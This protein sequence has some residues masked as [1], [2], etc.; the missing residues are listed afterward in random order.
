VDEVVAERIPPKRKVWRTVGSPRLLIIG[1]YEMGFELK[2]RTSGTELC[3]WIDYE[4]PSR[5]VGRSLGR[6]FSTFYARWCVQQMVSDA[7]RHF[8]PPVAAAI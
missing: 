2:P 1:W 3:V 4:L 6:L 8:L 5:G 7:V